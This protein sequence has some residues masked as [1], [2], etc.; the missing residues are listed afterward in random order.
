MRLP[1]K[2]WVALENQ[3]GVRLREGKRDLSSPAASGLVVC[4][5]LVF[6]LL[7]D[8][9]PPSPPCKNLFALNFLIQ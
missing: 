7:G 3:V 9:T 5:T 4:G 1:V 2:Y 8:V 6:P